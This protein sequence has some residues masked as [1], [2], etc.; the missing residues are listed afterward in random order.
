MYLL[1]LAGYGPDILGRLCT[2]YSWQVM[3]LLFLAGV[4][5]LFLCKLPTVCLIT[6]PDEV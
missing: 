5:E 1:F 3:D 6:A 2:C 4:T